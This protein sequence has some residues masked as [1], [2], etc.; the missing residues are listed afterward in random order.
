MILNLNIWSP[1]KSDRSEDKLLTTKVNNL[2]LDEQTTSDEV[3]EY[4]NSDFEEVVVSIFYKGC[5]FN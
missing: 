3:K 5:W 1:E 2:K 4:D